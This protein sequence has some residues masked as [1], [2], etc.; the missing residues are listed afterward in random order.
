MASWHSP[1]IVSPSTGSLPKLIT[2]TSTALA[3]ASS[4]SHLSEELSPSSSKIILRNAP[5]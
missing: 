5:M 2:I 1:L 4:C 3:K